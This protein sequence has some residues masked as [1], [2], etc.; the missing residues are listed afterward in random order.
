M[1]EAR[2]LVRRF[3]PVV[4]VADATFSIPP[5]SIAGIL[6]PNGA[7]KSTTIRM[8]VGA[9]EPTSGSV[10]IAGADMWRS[11]LTARAR[12]GY[13][14][15]HNALH[16]ELRVVELL[17]YRGRLHGL[18]GR[19]L[20]LAVDE[21]VQRCQLAP[22]RRR[23]VGALSK[24]YRQ[25]VGL[26][27]ALLHQPQVLILDE[28]TSGLDPT[29]IVEFRALLRSLRGQQTVL[30]SSHVLAEIEALCDRLV[31]IRAGRV[32]AQGTVEEIRRRTGAGPRLLV[33]AA[34][35]LAA[36]RQA[37]AAALPGLHGTQETTAPPG[38]QLA[39][40]LEIPCRDAD[41]VELRARVGREFAAR[42]IALR[43]LTTRRASLED[44]FGAI[45]GPSVASP[46][47][48]AVAA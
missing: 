46:T 13:L 44:L 6:G 3:G 5:G 47:S 48:G 9:L 31:M 1:V 12:L 17:R 41:D 36:I 11:P 4:A 29:Q 16:P 19:R 42:G 45:A 28:P 34:G 33:E 8:L 26:A 35:D 30:L 32:A 27:A 15:E 22:M 21:A 40:R 24:G 39:H 2:S 14:P 7:G 37:L 38:G 20:S 25:R 10:M 43:E 23:L 18:G